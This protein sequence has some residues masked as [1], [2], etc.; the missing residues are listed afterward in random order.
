MNSKRACE[1][2]KKIEEKYYKKIYINEIN[3]WPLIRLQLWKYF[4]SGINIDQK[5]DY[6]L[7]LKN[8]FKKAILNL[9]IYS[10]TDRNIFSKNIF[11]SKKEALSN[12]KIENKNYDRIIDPIFQLSKK[13]IKL[14]YDV[15][16]KLD[17]NL[18][19]NSS[20]VGV[21]FNLFE[22][23]KSLSN[24]LKKIIKNLCK[25]N[26]INSRTFIKDFQNEINE[27]FNWYSFG[28]KLFNKYKFLKKLFIYPWYS[29]RM[30]G[31]I[32]ASKNFNISSYDI[33][34][35]IQ[36]S[37]QA[38][39]THWM[40]YPEEGYLMVP[41]N[42]LVWNKITRRC[43]LKNNSKLFK[44]KHLTI[45]N[46][47]LKFN[48]KRK[49][50]KTNNVKKVL[51]CAQPSTSNNNEVVP[52]F[53]EKFIKKYTNKRLNFIIRLHPNDRKNVN[54]IYK[55][56]DNEIEK[57]FVFIDDA[58]FSI[59]YTFQDIS[60]CISSF[61]TSSIE[62]S[63]FGIKSAIFGTDA[64]LIMK[65]FLSNKNLSLIK[66]NENSLKNWLTH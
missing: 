19:F 25:Q 59:Y 40:K 13:K 18:K 36:G 14:Y 30:M 32:A 56:F 24:D 64:E 53:I 65:D 15:D 48:I 41:S 60:H 57:N 20:R 43:H 35:G 4:T 17:L 34:H 12:L 7:I 49:N 39:Y 42:F 66:K 50:K 45:L 51:F 1:I 46:Q 33:Q 58:K 27:F 54:K 21:Y 31:L 9:K 2:I 8:I 6:P 38:M 10:F 37:H 23:Q 55:L 52:K 61:S 44:R 11:F 62:A 3:F 28:S 29:S 63:D 26:K 5:F 22:P 16:L 47:K